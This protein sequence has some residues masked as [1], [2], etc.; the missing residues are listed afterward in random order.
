MSIPALSG[1]PN[2]QAQAYFSTRK[3]DL[4]HL[5]GALQSGNLDN[6]KQAFQA[7]LNL[8]ENGPFKNGT[9]FLNTQRQ[10]DFAAIGQALQS[11][12]LAGARQAFQALRQTFSTKVEPSPP[13]A[14]PSGPVVS[15]NVSF[16]A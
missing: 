9:P 11:G 2:Q 12:D 15:S 10:Q 16:V 5:H 6:A 14:A 13:V 1:L 4:S 8:G 7:I 3:T